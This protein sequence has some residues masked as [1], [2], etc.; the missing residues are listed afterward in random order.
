MQGYSMHTDWRSLRA[1]SSYDTY[2]VPLPLLLLLLLLI[3]S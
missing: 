1:L 2:T 3:A